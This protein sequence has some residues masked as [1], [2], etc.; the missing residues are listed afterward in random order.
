MVEM[1][2][3]YFGRLQHVIEQQLGSMERGGGAHFDQN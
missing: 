2:L 1:E 3:K